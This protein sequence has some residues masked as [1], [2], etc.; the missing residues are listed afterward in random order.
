MSIK[1]EITSR[2]NGLAFGYLTWLEKGLRSG[3]VSGPY[4]K[5]ELPHYLYHAP[6]S[7]LVDK[8]SSNS[9]YCDSLNK[10]WFQYLDP[11]FSSDRTDLGIHPDGN[12]S[13]T[14]GCIG[15]V[16]A[17]TSAWYNAFKALGTE[18]HTVVEVIDNT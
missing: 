11:Q 13:G 10:C 1:F 18:E 6:R 4:G 14:L 17:D 5:R 7:G 12:K 2:E 8:L 15:I 16:D 9:A 3:A